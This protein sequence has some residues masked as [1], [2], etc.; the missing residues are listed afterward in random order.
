MKNANLKDAARLQA[1]F[2]TLGDATRLRI[3][4]FIGAEDRSVSEIVDF[5][6][7]SQPLVSHHLRVL[8][9]SGILEAK[10]H[11][12]FIR[13]SVKDARLLDALGILQEIAPAGEVAPGSLPMFCRPPWW[14]GFR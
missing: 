3:I 4:Q 9:E 12:P 11:G 2:Q 10:R 7:Q 5:L 6:R 14:K 8:R 1:F 13:Y